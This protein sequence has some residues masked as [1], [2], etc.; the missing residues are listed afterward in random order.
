MIDL[1]LIKDLT[2]SIAKSLSF[3]DIELIGKYFFKNYNTHKLENIPDSM[4]I[5]PQTAARRLVTECQENNKIDDFFVFMIETDGTPLNGK[6]IKLVGLEN[7]LYRLSKT[8]KFFDFNK[9]KIVA[10]NSEKT[11]LQNWGALKEGKEYPIIIAS[12]DIC[13]NSELVKKYNTSIMEK[14]YYRFSN[15]LNHKLSN[16]NGR[17]WSW[18][19][20]GGLIAFRNEKGPEY[21]VSC[22]L[23]LFHC[24]M[25]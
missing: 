16:F 23:D 17:V 2:E 6:T 20:D 14:V 15:Y 9:R 22:C 1:T 19:G 18:A 12:I 11:T 3:N 4:T 10:Y 24:E 21:A 8:G 7:I 13:Q 25:L 5:S